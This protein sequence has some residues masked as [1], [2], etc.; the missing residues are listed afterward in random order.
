MLYYTLILYM[1]IICS[2]LEF[3]QNIYHMD[4]QNDL[5]EEINR[6]ISQ[7]QSHTILSESSESEIVTWKDY[8][9]RV[10]LEFIKMGLRGITVLFT[11]GDHGT[12]YK[13]I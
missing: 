2:F 9:N 6:N 1:Y 10:E 11:A 8:A 12:V 3:E 4:S 13:Y 5:I 7:T